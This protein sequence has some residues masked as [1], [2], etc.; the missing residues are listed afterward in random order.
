MG[1]SGPALALGAARFYGEIQT[2][3]VGAALVCLSKCFNSACFCFLI[4][5]DIKS[6]NR[7]CPAGSF[8]SLGLNDL[9]IRLSVSRQ[10]IDD[11]DCKLRTF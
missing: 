9:G 1:I 10:Y 8:L 2:D 7:G 11:S 4:F 3:L 6:S 5:A